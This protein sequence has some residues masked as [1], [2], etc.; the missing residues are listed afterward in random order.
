LIWQSTLG[1]HADGFV[2]RGIGFVHLTDGDCFLYF[3][4]MGQFLFSRHIQ[5]PDT[6]DDPTEIY[7]L[8]NYEINQSFY[9]YSQKSKRPVDTLYIQA[10]DPTTVGQL[11]EL[12]GRDILEI[13][14][15]PAGAVLLD[16][17]E[18][19]AVCQDFSILDLKSHNEPSI[20]YKPLRKEITWR[21]VQLAGIAIGV[22]LVVLLAV[23]ASFLHF[24]QAGMQQRQSVI[25]QSASDQQPELIFQDLDQIV[26][27]ISD[28]F[29]R[30][31]GSSVMMRTLLAMPTEVSLHKI[32]LDTADIPR[33]ILDASVDAKHPEAF[34]AIL[35]EF[36]NR[37]NQGFNLEDRPLRE[38][39]IQIGLER[40]VHNERSPIYQIHFSLQLI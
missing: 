22:L 36:L 26:N 30:Q 34:K 21:P 27:K 35:D 9:L 38:R 40:N 28:V 7:N 19:F 6:G 3:Y 4:H 15:S 37:M 29:G 32:T 8:L 11:S 1:R 10:K 18:T 16:D 20:S 25:L 13:P 31:S 2:E 39:D 12:L 24:R 33:L 23:E 5:L 17:G 14:P